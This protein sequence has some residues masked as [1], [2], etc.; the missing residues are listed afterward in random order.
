MPYDSALAVDT[1]GRAW[2]WGHNGG[3]ELCL[4]DTRDCLTPVR[5]P[6]SHVTALAGA[7]NH[8]LYDANGT[9]YAC[10]QNVE[11]GL[12]IGSRR[13]SSTP[14]KVP[15]L[16]G[17]SVTKL[18]AA[19]ANS[20]ALLSSGQ[21][22]DWGYDAGG[23]LGNGPPRRSADAPHRAKRAAPVTPGAHTRPTSG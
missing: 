18:V 13:S 17:S 20:G 7:S 16:S 9:V 11:G 5:L 21:Y 23:Q 1:E 2:G 8:A 3:G 22:F 12:G 6:L 10:G 19:V 4:G 15:G 14:V